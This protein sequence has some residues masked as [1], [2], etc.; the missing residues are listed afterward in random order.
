MVRP[1]AKT[2]RDE[3]RR[4]THEC[5]R[6][7]RLRILA[8]LFLAATAA[9][10]QSDR[11]T[12][13]GV[14][15][16]ETGAVIP[17]AAVEAVNQATGL[18]YATTSNGVG[19]YALPALPVGPYEVSVTAKG[20]R[21]EGWQGPVHVA[22]TTTL[23]FTMYIPT[24]NVDVEIVTAPLDQVASDN[25]T[26]ITEKLVTDLPLSV[27]GNM[28]NPES[29]IF[30]TPGVT[31]TASNTQ[32]D[33]SQSRA[34]EVLFD[35]VGATSPES[36]GTLFTYPSVEAISEFRLVNSDFSAE[37]GRT[38]GGFEV[39][40]SKSGTNAFH[41]AAFDYLRNNVFDARGFFAT[42]APVNRQNEFGAALGGPVAIPRVYNGRKRTF[43]YFVYSGFRYDQSSSNSLV[44]IPPVAFRDG[45]FSSLEGSSGKPI[46]IYDPS[47]TTLASSGAYTRTPFPGNQIPQSSFSSVSSKILPLLPQPT[48]GGNLNN[49]LALNGNSFSRDQVDLKI[50]HSFSDANRLSGFLYVGRQA[51]IS[52]DTLPDPF[53]NGLNNDYESRWARLS[54]DWTLSPN[55]LNHAAFGFTREAQLWNSLAANQNWPSQ[56][57]LTGVQTG[58]GNAFPYVTFSDGYTTWGSTNGTKTVGEQVNNVFQL[59]DSVG[60]ERGRHS[61]KFGADARWLQTNGADYFGSQ[62]NFAF[63]TLE[64]GLPGSSSTGSAFASFLLGD[65][66]Q[67]QLNQLTLVP[68]IRYRYLAGF[69]QDDWKI[70]RT[71]TLNLGLR[72]EIYFPRAE[73]HDNLAS[74]D[75]TLANPGAGNLP[76]AIEFLGTGPG[77]SGLTSFANT[78]Y[79][80]LGP[81]VGF[82]WAPWPGDTVLRGGYGIY[83]GPGNAD[84]GLRQSQSFGFGFNASPVFASPNNGVTPA[85]NW[86][87]GFPQNYVRPPDISPTVANGSAVTMIGAG[88]GRPP[89]FQ[90]W[91][92][93]VQQPLAD[94]VLVEIDY[95]GVKGTR[96]GTTLIQPN[97]LNPSYLSLGNLLSAPVTSAAAQAAGIPLPYPGFTG[98]VAQAL[99][100]F[101]QYLTITN[102]SN[103]NGDSTYHA[104]QMKVER[105]ISHGLTGV[106]AY[107]WSKTL[108]D[109]DTAA[110]GG[111]SGQTFYNRGLEKAVSDTDVPQA[112]SI[113]FL[114]DLPF[115]PGKRFFQHGGLG[116]LMAGWT[117][118]N[119]DQYWAGEPIVLTANNTLPLFN[120]TLRPNV[121][122]G[123]PLEM[124]Y[125]NFDPA[126]DRYINPAA[127]TVPAAFTLGSAARSYDSLRAPWNLNESVGA[128]KRTAINERVTLI[129]RAE[130][131]NVFNRVVFGAPASNISAANFGVVGSQSNA[132]RQGQ[133]ALRLEF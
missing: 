53:T 78:D 133:M 90:N 127:F 88:D 30:L 61:L 83:Y 120:S 119:I 121:I 80:N 38:G 124:S 79:K 6:H 43:F 67:G 104:L 10:A 17:G 63:N 45:N 92:V 55:L 106:V 95:V 70:S 4:G 58:A 7:G 107:A 29:F 23:N 125:N 71:L 44:S 73:A 114:Y 48:N 60:W 51:Q 33:G 110:G 3:S 101:P 103:P 77:R 9:M 69:A 59:D 102:L 13:T 62:G 35:G 94:D 132:P 16:D 75:P 50:D 49:F 85:F 91:S 130:F 112:V 74:F 72:Y 116:K 56:I 36:G 28:R 15:T 93:G 37:Y 96:L 39:F 123:V 5:V 115:G 105:R 84:A 20:F 87:S 131:F 32:I 26:G 18:K 128:V 19:I 81:R 21:T 46:L 113:S 1:T 22:A 117:L 108:T 24:L 40:S 89:Y 68:G 118:T 109:A 64:T 111:P 122:S 100:P 42:A 41:G 65:V 25:S 12:I 76:G 98:S 129:F 14:L 47:S 2:R 66:H 126:V 34:K 99:R 86:D 8:I 11:S 57:G 27:S 31:G 82:A 97:E 52:A 54:D